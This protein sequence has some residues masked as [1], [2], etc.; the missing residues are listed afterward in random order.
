VTFGIVSGLGRTGVGTDYEDFIQTDASINPGNSGGALVDSRGRLVGVNT[1]ILSGQGRGNIG[2]GFAVPVR[3]ALSVVEQLQ[4]FGE[5]QRGRLGVEVRDLT[6]G[7]AEALDIDHVG[8]ALIT[9]VSEG[10]PGRE[11]GLEVGD[12]VIRAGDL[13]IEGS[14]D[15]RNF[16]GLSRPDV[17]FELVILR[18]GEERAI[19]VTL[20]PPDAGASATALFGAS[21]RP[22]TEDNPISQYVE[23]I[24]VSGIEPGSLA[25]ERGLREGDVV[26]HIN[27]RPVPDLDA[28]GEL[29]EDL[30]E[31]A[32]LTVVRGNN[33]LLVV[34][35]R[36]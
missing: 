28:F 7:V 10:S 36:S 25:A 14:T 13:E 15:L 12:I 6:A 29:R 34:L 30:S 20:R 5:V 4:T 32:A 17:A 16:V 23:G 22:L 8:G 11:A 27:R 33:E 9:Q 19:T 2:I 3:M 21:F 26:T 1:A 35:E 18:D 31:V 24:V